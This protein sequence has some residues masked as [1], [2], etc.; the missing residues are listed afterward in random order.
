MTRYHLLINNKKELII[1]LHRHK[2]NLQYKISQNYNE[3]IVFTLPGT[4]F[5]NATWMEA[6]MA[7]TFSLIIVCELK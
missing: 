2:I 5:Y 1:I 6:I 3:R 7:L 4:H